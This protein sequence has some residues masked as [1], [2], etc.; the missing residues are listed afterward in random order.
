MP[1]DDQINYNVKVRLDPNDD[2][3]P[4]DKSV[5]Y[6]YSEKKF[7][8]STAVSSDI[9]VNEGDDRITVSNN[10]NTEVVAQSFFRYIESSNVGTSPGKLQ[11]GNDTSAPLHLVDIGQNN[12]T[13]NQIIVSSTTSPGSFLRLGMNDANTLIAAFGSKDNSS[14]KFQIGTYPDESNTTFT[15]LVNIN[16]EGEVGI[17]ID[18]E[19]NFISNPN[20]LLQ[21]SG[22]YLNSTIAVGEP[23]AVLDVTSTSNNGS[24]L[25]KAAIIRIKKAIGTNGGSYDNPQ[26]IDFR[27]LGNIPNPNE[28]DFLTAGAIVLG[29]DGVADLVGPSDV[30]LKTNIK[31]LSVGLKELLK[32]QPR[33]FTWIDSSTLGKGFVAQELYK[34]FPEAVNVPHI[35]DNPIKSPWGIM[36]TK[37]IPLLVN[38]IQDQQKIIDKLEK[39]ITQLEN[40]L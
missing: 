18:Y 40:K 6:D 7:V 14:Q 25:N 27:R 37:L 4:T 12:A 23:I 19:G 8:L 1:H 5:I 36:P 34:I 31:P 9:V 24:E 13:N 17:G 35:K 2:S 20:S 39:R 3:T 30:R 10:T 21:I 28:P 16:H 26:F 33:E 29:P 11:I 22:D 38:S 32:I 15:P